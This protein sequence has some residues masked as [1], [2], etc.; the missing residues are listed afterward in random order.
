MEDKIFD[1]VNTLMNDF[2]Q[3]F[4]Y[5]V[6]DMMNDVPQPLR[7]VAVAI[8]QAMVNSYLEVM[9]ENAREV[10]DS[11]LNHIALVAVPPELDPRKNKEGE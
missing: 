1:A 4:A 9:P 3:R 8:V 2:M 5:R 10:Y 11:C 6:S 7:P